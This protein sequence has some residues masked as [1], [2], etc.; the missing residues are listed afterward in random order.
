MKIACFEIQD[1]E[2]QYLSDKLKG[3]F[4]L[5]FFETPIDKV[6]LDTFKDAEIIVIF[7]YSHIDSKTLESLPNLKSIVTMSTGFDHIDIEEC[8]RRNIAVSN[9]PKY[10]ETTVA[11]HTFAL[12]LAI[13]RRLKESFDRVEKGTY[14]PEGLTGFDLK[15]KTLGVV[16]VGNIGAHVVKIAKGFDMQVLGYKRNPDQNLAS[17]LG[18]SFVA[19]DTLLSTSDI[20]TL[21]IPYAGDTHHLL[22]QERFAKMRQGAIVINTSRGAVLDTKALLQALESGKVGGAGLDVLEEE[23]ILRE[24]KELLSKEFD[25]EKLLSVLESHML[26]RH[27][28]VVITPHNAFNSHEALTK[29]LDT[30]CENIFSYVNGSPQNLVA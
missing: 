29:I 21:H 22:N 1:W 2:K 23:P 20:I 4:E 25:R 15:G 9:I 8:K 27:P 18:F 5:L 10:G 24:E 14:S 3:R 19:L 6:S 26:F 16:G 13:S 30:T 28:K 17:Q 7:I 12:I 11:E